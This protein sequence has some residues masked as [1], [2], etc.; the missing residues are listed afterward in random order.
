MMAEV[1]DDFQSKLLVH[2]GETWSISQSVV[3]YYDL[4]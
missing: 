3:C 4:F 1:V 2:L